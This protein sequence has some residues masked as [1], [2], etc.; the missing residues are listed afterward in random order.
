LGTFDC[1]LGLK[2]VGVWVKT[3]NRCLRVL[4]GFVIYEDG[5]LGIP[6]ES[7]MFVGLDMPLKATGQ[8]LMPS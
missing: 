6:D 1:G 8:L 5:W 2:D 4:L 7:M 3:F